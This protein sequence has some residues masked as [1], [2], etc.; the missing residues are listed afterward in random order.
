MALSFQELLL[1]GFVLVVLVAILT[2]LGARAHGRRKSR[3]HSNGGE[4]TRVR[5]R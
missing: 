2:N 4:T 3:R 5:R 1:L